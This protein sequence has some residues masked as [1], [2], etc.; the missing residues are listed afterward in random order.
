M[1]KLPVEQLVHPGAPSAVAPC[2]GVACGTNEAAVSY[3]FH[4]G[5]GLANRVRAA[6][7]HRD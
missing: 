3:P 6:V 5:A 1:R 4:C 2:L 7:T